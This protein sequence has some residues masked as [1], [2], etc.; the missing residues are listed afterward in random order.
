MP[1]DRRRCQIGNN[2]EIP[3]IPGYRNNGGKAC[4]EIP[5]TATMGEKLA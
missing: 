2:A 3:E 5:A 4:I 1:C